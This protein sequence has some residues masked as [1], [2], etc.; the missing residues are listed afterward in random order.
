ME[1]KEELLVADKFMNITDVEKGKRL[2]YFW[3]YYKVPTLVIIAIIII[4]VSL[5]KTIFF[6]TE[7]DTSIFLTTVNENITTSLTDNIEK[8]LKENTGDLNEDGENSVIFEPIILLEDAEDV[9]AQNMLATKFTAVLSV[10]KYIIEIVDEDTFVYLKE[11]GL[12]ADYSVL[13]DYGY[14][15]D[16]TGDVKIPVFDTSLKEIKGMDEFSDRLYLTLRPPTRKSDLTEKGKAE[17]S[18]Q[19]KLFV[20]FIK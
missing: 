11:Q 2:Q 1:I 8:F 9:E 16:K 17:Y 6:G 5:V 20:D 15:T 4:V 14:E 7:P 3:E 19:I 12:V 13:K 10:G 18:R